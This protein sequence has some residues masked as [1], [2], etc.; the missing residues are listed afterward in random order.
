MSAE[1][2]NIRTLLARCRREE[3]EELIIRCAANG[4]ITG[5]EIAQ[6]NEKSPP[7]AEPSPLARL[8]HSQ[9]SNAEDTPMRLLDA[10]DTDLFLQVASWL[11]S[12]A[13]ARLAQVCR[14]MHY[15]VST[16]IVDAIQA[17][18]ERVHPDAA[19]IAS[20]RPPPSRTLEWVEQVF[21]LARSWGDIAQSTRR[22]KEGW[23][24]PSR[25]WR[26]AA[27]RLAMSANAPALVVAAIVAN[28]Q[29]HSTPD[30]TPPVPAGTSSAHPNPLG[31]ATLEWAAP[32]FPPSRRTSPVR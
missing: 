4:L 14:R 12:S 23:G 10:L 1:T 17:A 29:L 25:L 27:A 2:A 30:H 8:L 7:A 31:S 18:G 13:L 6:L 26:D 16:P 20:L 32:L 28:I 21:G 3:L 5:S 24:D 15:G 11:D 22:L 19:L 9:S